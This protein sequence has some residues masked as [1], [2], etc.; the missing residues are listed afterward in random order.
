MEAVSIP[1]LNNSFESPSVPGTFLVGPPTNWSVS[2]GLADEFVEDTAAV[3]MT[4]GDG[5]QYAGLDTAGGYIYHRPSAAT[6]RT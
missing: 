1:I 3:G 6:T 2:A 4:G 5:L